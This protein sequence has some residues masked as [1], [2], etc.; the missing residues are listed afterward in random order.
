MNGD[1]R[2]PKC[3]QENCEIAIKTTKLRNKIA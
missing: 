1:Y 3:T 2:M